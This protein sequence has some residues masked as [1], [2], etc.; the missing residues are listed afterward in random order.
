MSWIKHTPYSKAN[1][2]RNRSTE[3]SVYV[4]E[5][6]P[7]GYEQVTTRSCYV[8]TKKVEILPQVR[9]NSLIYHNGN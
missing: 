3:E 9:G 8:V 6:H 5:V 4:V 7:L 2:I 1:A